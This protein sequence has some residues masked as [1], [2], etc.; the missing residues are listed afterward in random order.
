MF[1]RLKLILRFIL[2]S[3]RTVVMLLTSRLTQRISKTKR[4]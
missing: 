4:G 3:T 2:L 1:E